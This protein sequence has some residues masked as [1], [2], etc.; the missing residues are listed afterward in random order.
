M[1]W[2][3]EAILK[4]IEHYYMLKD[5]KINP[6]IEVFGGGERTAIRNALNRKAPFETLAILNAEFS[7]AV[8]G[9]RLFYGIDVSGAFGLPKIEARRHKGVGK[10]ITLLLDSNNKNSTWMGKVMR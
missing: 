10:L 6:W 7:L 3:K 9:V 8:R 1:R 5:Y 2:A 4:W